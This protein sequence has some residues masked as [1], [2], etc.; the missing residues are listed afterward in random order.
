MVAIDTRI[1]S[2]Y[3][4]PWLNYWYCNGAGTSCNSDTGEGLVFL[5]EGYLDDPKYVELGTA[6]TTDA[7]APGSSVLSQASA[8]SIGTDPASV[9][10]STPEGCVPISEASGSTSDRARATIGASIGAPLAALLGC[11][12]FGHYERDISDGAPRVRFRIANE[13]A[14]V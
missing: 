9:P 4:G 11:V 10:V 8:T 3:E 5:E 14:A 13:T 2:C 7:E 1:L 12:I 6:T